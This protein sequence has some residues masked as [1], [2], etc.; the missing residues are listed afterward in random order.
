ME[1]RDLSS[2]TSPTAREGRPQS[3]AIA[4][5]DPFDLDVSVLEFGDV[6]AIMSGQTDDNCGSTCASPCVTNVG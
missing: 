5:P 6:T 3:G 2:L 4:E 1:T